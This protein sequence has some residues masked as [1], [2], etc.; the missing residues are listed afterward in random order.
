MPAK[1]SATPV[2]GGGYALAEAYFAE[3]APDKRALLEQL[4]AIVSKALPDATVAIKWGVPMFLVGGR[5]VCGLA[6]FK[7]HVKLNFFGPPEVFADPKGVLTGAGKN[8]RSLDVRTAKD[9]DAASVRRWLKA[10][11][12][13]GK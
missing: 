10:A 2:A 5:M 7:E 6:A 8:N 3:Q 1:K 9:I 13:A 11:A 12:A 4:G